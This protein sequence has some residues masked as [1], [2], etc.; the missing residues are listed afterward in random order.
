MSWEVRTMR[1]RIS[2]FDATAFRKNV[3]RFAP[4][5]VL[6]SVFM[7][8]LMLSFSGGD[9]GV[10]FASALADMTHLTGGVGLAYALLNAQLLFGDLYNSRMCNALHA[11]PISRQAWFGTHVVSGLAFCVIPNSVFALLFLLLSGPV[12]QAPLLWLAV[13]VLQ[14]IFFFGIAVLSAYCVGNRFAM[15]LVYGIINFFSMIVYWLVV[16]LYEPLL[17]GITVSDEVFTLL[18]PAAQLIGNDYFGVDY[19]YT[20]IGNIVFR[21]L[22]LETGWLYLA[23]STVVGIGAVVLALVVYLR[24]NLE[25][26]G[27]FMAV[28]R[29]GP[30]FLVL[31][32]LCAGAC[33]HG[34]FS[35]FWGEENYGFL[36]LGLAIGFFTGLM[37][38]SRTVRVFRKKNI[39][40]FLV[41]MAVFVLTL[42]L[43][44]IDPLGITRWVPKAEQVKSVQ[45]S[46]GGGQYRAQSE[47]GL[48]DQ[49][50]IQKILILHDR[51]VKDRNHAYNGQETV[52]VRL[53][54]TLRGGTK[55]YRE[56]ILELDEETKPLLKSI[57]TKPEVVLGSLYTERE[58]HSIVRAEISEF[59][60][61]FEENRAL[62]GLMEAIILDCE[63]G[64]M[65]QDWAFMEDET[66]SSWIYLEARRSDGIYYGQDIRFDKTCKHIIAWLEANS[67]LTL[68]KM[69]SGEYGNKFK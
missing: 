46:T 15:A 55:A 21:Q 66:F 44:V 43:T 7:L 67:E 19:D 61:T 27:D 39:L 25:S 17:Y 50:E 60:V 3:T 29:T 16:S 4:A 6:Y 12:W 58:K 59:G 8:M 65:A 34:F 42:V 32:T 41:L 5:W 18:C 57:L 9:T 24:R 40:A 31:Y 33:C 47:N 68:E 48:R 2:F 14:Y 22:N 69:M 62:E 20:S 37:L 56:Y 54:Y 38:L 13:S 63:A 35:L 23:I 28:K 64:N 11:M 36:V 49:D 26:A 30:V 53:N 45:I 1:S 51:C 52:R 10:Q